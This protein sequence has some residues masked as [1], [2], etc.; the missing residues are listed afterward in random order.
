MIRPRIDLQIAGRRRWENG[1]CDPRGS[2]GRGESLTSSAAGRQRITCVGKP[3][4]PSCDPYRELTSVGTHFSC[5]LIAHTDVSQAPLSAGRGRRRTA[6]NGF[7]ERPGSSHSK[8]GPFKAPQHPCSRP[9]RYEGFKYPETAGEETRTQVQRTSA[10]ASGGHAAHAV[11]AR[12]L[13][14]KA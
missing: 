4:D 8:T 1:G 2:R 12:L 7:R 9:A 13:G 11:V 5:W 6:L 14:R 3:E 10:S